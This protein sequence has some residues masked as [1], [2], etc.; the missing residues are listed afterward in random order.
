MWPQ[1]WNASA[2]CARSAAATTPVP[3]TARRNLP[4]RAR[5][6]R[7]ELLSATASLS[8]HRAG[9]VGQE[10]L[11]LEER[12][13]RPLRENVSVGGEDH[14][15]RAS[16]DVERPP[17]LGIR[18]LVEELDLDLR[19]GGNEAQRRLECPA[20][21]AARRREDGDC[22]WRGP[23]EPLDQ[24]EPAAELRPFLVQRQ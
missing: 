21:R 20:E 2:C 13:E 14:R 24:V 11:E 17:G 6:P 4:A 18:L 15:V 5:N 22:E 23:V 16:R 10:A 3:L 1:K 7:R 9:R 12:V 19:V 8:T